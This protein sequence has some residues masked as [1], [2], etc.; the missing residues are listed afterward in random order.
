MTPLPPGC[1]VAYEICFTVTELT[2]EMGEWF[3]MIG[4]RA[5]KVLSHIDR[6]DREHFTKQVQYGQGRLSHSIKNNNNTDRTLIRFDGA[7]ASVA[8]VFLLKFMDE[9]VQHNLREAENYD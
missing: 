3:N 1:R 5:T 2:D 8:S 9:I 7:D 4:G 6:H